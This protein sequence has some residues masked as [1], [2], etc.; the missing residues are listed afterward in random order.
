MA[1]RKI[2]FLNSQPVLQRWLTILFCNYIIECN[3]KDLEAIFVIS[4]K[5]LKH[6][7]TDADGK[8]VKA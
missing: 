5:G 7:Y 8:E 3:E 1:K 4:I 6:Y 2:K